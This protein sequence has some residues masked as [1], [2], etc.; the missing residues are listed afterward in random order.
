[1]ML[2]R[3]LVML[4]VLAAALYAAWS[5]TPATVRNRW[6]L[7]LANSLG[8]PQ[9]SGVRGRVAQWLQRIGQAPAGGCSDCP[10]HRIATPAERAAQKQDGAQS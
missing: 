9:A 7:G 10:A 6:A 3:L 5:L 4:I 1:M 2:E 8:G